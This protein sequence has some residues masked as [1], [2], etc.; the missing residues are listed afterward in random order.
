M[1]AVSRAGD[2][3]A[4]S[5][6]SGLRQG[7]ILSTTNRETM[8]SRA[9]R[10][11][12][13]CGGRHL[14]GFINIDFPG[15]WTGVEPD[16]AHDLS[17]AL[18][19]PDESVD[20]AHAYHLFEHFYRYDAERILDDWC[21]TLKPG[22][23]LVL[24]LPCLDKILGLFDLYMTTGDKVPNNYTMWGLFGDPNY[25][26]PHMCHKWCYSIAELSGLVSA[27]GLS[28]TLEE[29]KTHQ[30]IRDMRIVGV[31]DGT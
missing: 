15:N 11:N 5:G 2:A 8:A 17:T 12:L 27:C 26:N 3:K 16:L 23:R 14:K 6:L 21:R 18:P 4:H 28:A 29:P 9:V 10:L 31:K 22:G 30:P 19:F 13:G 20:E 24:E 7:R 1:G 25:K